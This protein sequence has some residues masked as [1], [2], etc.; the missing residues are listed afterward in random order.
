[1]QCVQS[2]AIRQLDAARLPLL[3]F[4]KFKKSQQKQSPVRFF[5]TIPAT[6]LIVLAA[7][8]TAPVQEMSNARQAVSAAEEAGASEHAPESLGAA[9]ALLTSAER[10][11]EDGNFRGA[12]LDAVDAK[13]H[14]VEALQNTRDAL[15]PR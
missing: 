1:M 3:A 11:L 9:R 13:T 8:A 10:K 4:R 12:R 14:A 15:S 7:C 5:F 6:V 2:L